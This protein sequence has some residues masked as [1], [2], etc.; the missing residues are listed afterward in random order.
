MAL[1]AISFKVAKLAV[2]SSTLRPQIAANASV[3]DANV[4]VLM[5]NFIIE[6]PPLVAAVTCSA[7]VSQTRDRLLGWRTPVVPAGCRLA[8]SAWRNGSVGFHRRRVIGV[9]R[10]I[11]DHRRGVIVVNLR[12]LRAANREHRDGDA[13]RNC[14]QQMAHFSLLQLG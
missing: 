3:V 6:L 1:Q 8:G 2:G 14:Q 4:F 7:Q 12:G 11:C 9:N 13:A 10:R 5:R